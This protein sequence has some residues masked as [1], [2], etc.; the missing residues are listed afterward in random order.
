MNIVMIG[1]GYVGL[2]TGACLAHLGHSVTCVESDP[3]RLGPLRAGDIPIYEPGLADVVQACRLSGRLQFADPDTPAL[4][5]ADVVMLAVGTPSG[6]DGD[7]DLAQIHEAA[8]QIAP[9]LR[10]G[11]VIAIKSTVVAGTARSVAALVARARGAGD[12]AVVSNPEFLREGSALADFLTA[13][14]IVVGADD[15]AAAGVMAALYAPLTE[16]GVPYVRTGTIDA[17]LIK[18]AANACLALRIGFV[19]E[20]ADLCEAAGG[21]IARV[22]EGIGLDSRIGPRFLQAG[23]G[24]GGSCF[25]KDTRAFAATGRR[26]GARQT[27][28]EALIAANEARKTALAGRILQALDARQNGTERR[29]RRVAVLGMAFKAGTD[30]VRDAAALSV[31]PAL[32]AAG[33]TVTGHD[34]KARDQA[35]ALLPGVGWADDPYDAA[36]GADAVVILTEWEEYRR[37]DLGRLAQRMSGKLLFDFRNLLCPD[38]AARAG[39]DCIGIGRAAPPGTTPAQHGTAPKGSGGHARVRRGTGWLQVAASPS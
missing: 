22:T 19:N 26:L 32:T 14:R 37:L 20:L 17:E 12:V 6:A 27:V 3:R 7:I 36:A 2:T 29:P 33:V 16:Q 31:V 21:D 23:P 28:I 11:A 13:D 34:P 30:D 8:R 35:A 24:F 1:A 5:T 9:R 38:A 10:P 18:Y 15:P 4:G 25:P 39:L